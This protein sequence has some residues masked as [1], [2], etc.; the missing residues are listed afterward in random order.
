MRRCLGW[1]IAA[2][3]AATLTF[4]GSGTTA[5][6]K[7]R[8]GLVLQQVGTNDPYNAPALRGF[9]RAV[10]SLGIKGRVVVASPSSGALPSIAYL[11]RQKYDLVIGYGYLIV[12]AM[13]AAAL[14]FPDTKFAIIDAS[15]KDLP[16][17]P[18]NVRGGMF[19]AEQPSYLA[20]Y[21]AALME[22]HRPGKDT[23]GAVGG[24]KIPTVDHFIAGYRAGA[25]RATSRGTTLI[26]Y[27]GSFVNPAKCNAVAR[28]QIARGAGVVFQVAS[29]C[30]LGA[31]DAAREEGVW[32]IGVDIDQSSLGPHVLTSALKRL[33][34]AVFA[35]VSA[36][37]RGTFRTGGDAVFDLRSGGVGLGKISA[38][39]PRAYVR[40]LERV[41]ARIVAGTIT[42]P[43]VLG[44]P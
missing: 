20:G 28:R 11:A 43:A 24:Y 15:Q 39:V 14:R 41:R 3:V 4:A 27:A 17:K 30:G 7:L 23:I 40:R 12:R 9:R 8:V 26:G 31:L 1:M 42:V 33:D 29:S 36:L 25:R 13:D 32:G 10:R 5:E 44:K 37:Q 34:V 35:T 21:L 2:V 18:K 16:H 19:A 38:K 22:R 6:S